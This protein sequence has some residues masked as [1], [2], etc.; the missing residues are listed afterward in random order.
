VTWLRRLGWATVAA[1][2]L[3]LVIGGYL[4]QLP[5]PKAAFVID[6][7]VLQPGTGRSQDVTL[8]LHSTTETNPGERQRFIGRFFLPNAPAD[9]LFLLVATPNRHLKVT[10]NTQ[11]LFDSKSTAI[12]VGP[13]IGSPILVRL[14]RPLLVVGQNEFWIDVG[15]GQF[16][17]SI[18]LPKIFIGSEAALTPV[19]KQQLWINERLK[20][21]SLVAQLLLG[22]GIIVAHFFRPRD[23]LLSWMAGMLTANFVL[24][25]GFFLGFNPEFQAIL[26]YLTVVAPAVGFLGIGVAYGVVGLPPPRA[27]AVLAF[28]IPAICML[29]ILAGIMPSRTVPVW[30][31]VGILLGSLTAGTGIIAWGALCRASTEA[32]L[33]LAPYVLL[34][35]FMLRDAAVTLGL[36]ERPLVVITPYVRPIFLIAV[37]AVLMRR[38]VTSLNGLDNA[39]E[40]LSRRL[41]EQEAQLAEL[42]RTERVEA[43]QLVREQERLRLTRDLHDGI[44]GHLVSIIAMTERG[45]TERA[46]ADADPIE[47]AARRALDDLRLVIYSLDLGERDLALALANFRE[48]LI[49]QL[50]RAGVELDWSIADLPEVS[51]VTPSN[52][53]SILRILQEALTNA[54]KHGPARKIIIRG[55]P[56]PG[57]VAL[58]VENDGRPFVEADRGYGLQNMRRRATELDGE[59][60]IA[61]LDHGTRLTLVLPLCLP[62]VFEAAPNATPSPLPATPR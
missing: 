15:G 52:A 32:R 55:S 12:W 38:L 53:L 11:P 16:A 43:A 44:S 48:R 49:P 61:V 25:I 2:T 54:L 62:N 29:L 14:P 4:V 57:G 21:M 59:F 6:R 45:G 9:D 7:G 58:T 13:V 37:I 1:A 20:T 31:G 8:P 3:A 47:E 28:A 42:H 41:I 33:M 22:L 18:Y 36:I 19:F 50:R 26:P 39:N 17:F 60:T 56:A 40:N 51:G 46:G 24:V 35:T 30:V 10:L 5:E 34:C 27:V 23:T